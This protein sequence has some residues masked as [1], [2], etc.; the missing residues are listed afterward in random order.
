[1][2]GV[3]AIKMRNIIFLVLLFPTLVLAGNYHGT[4]LQQP[5]F[6]LDQVENSEFIL[7]SLQT[8]KIDN[9]NLSIYLKNELLYQIKYKLSGSV[10]I[11][12]QDDYYWVLYIKDNNTLVSTMLTFKRVAND[13]P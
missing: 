10:I 13:K 1:M 2:L 6:P 5:P 8:L 12:N 7:N 9:K 4:Y 11:A 3:R